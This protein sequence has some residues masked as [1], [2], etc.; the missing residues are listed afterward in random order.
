MG[1]SPLT[2][3]N[4]VLLHDA[5]AIFVQQSMSEMW[6]NGKFGEIVEPQCHIFIDKKKQIAVMQLWNHVNRLCND[7]YMRIS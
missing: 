6:T 7:C 5:G 2:K 1:I 3:I 4:F